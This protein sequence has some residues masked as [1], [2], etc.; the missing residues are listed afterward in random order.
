MSS[1]MALNMFTALEPFSGGRDGGRSLYYQPFG[2]THS[3][4]A[5]D[6]GNA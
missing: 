6:L 3:L 4:T 2:D 1:P 5:V